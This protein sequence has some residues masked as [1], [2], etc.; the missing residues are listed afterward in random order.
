MLATNPNIVSLK[1]SKRT[2]ES[3]PM[4]VRKVPTSVPVRIEN[5]TIMAV[6]HTSIIAT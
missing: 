2:A 5:I 3:A 6:N 4:A 1:I